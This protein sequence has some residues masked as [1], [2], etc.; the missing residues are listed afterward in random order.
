MNRGIGVMFS[1]TKE[2]SRMMAKLTFSIL[3]NNKLKEYYAITAAKTRKMPGLRG[4]A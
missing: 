4:R 3:S 2:R 1:G